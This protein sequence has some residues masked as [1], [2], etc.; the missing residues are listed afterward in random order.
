M[1]VM[2][3]SSMNPD[4]AEDGKSTR[5][6]QPRGAD[7][8]RARAKVTVHPATIRASLRR[9]MVYPIELDQPLG[10]QMRPEKLLEFLSHGHPSPTLGMLTAVHIFRHG[11]NNGPAIIKLI[12]LVDGKLGTKRGR[13]RELITD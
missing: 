11:F 4:I 9:L 7:P 1:T 13:N 10:P 2:L 8:S 12:D 3:L 5:F 6:G